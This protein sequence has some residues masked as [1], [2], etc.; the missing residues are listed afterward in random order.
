MKALFDCNAYMGKGKGHPIPGTAEHQLHTILANADFFGKVGGSYAQILGKACL[1][2]RFIP[3]VG[4][5]YLPRLVYQLLGSKATATPFETL[6]YTEAGLLGPLRPEDMKM[7][8]ASFSG[9][10]GTAED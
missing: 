6:L 10:Y 1:L 5:S 2:L 4:K 3:G 8:V 7:I 9:V